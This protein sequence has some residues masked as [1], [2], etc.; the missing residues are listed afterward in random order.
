LDYFD[1]IGGMSKT[2]PNA[3]CRMPIADTGSK[4][5]NGRSKKI[6]TTSSL[7]F[8]NYLVLPSSMHLSAEQL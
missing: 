7:P 5:F 4:F 8:S 1:R 3:E 6:S 2:H